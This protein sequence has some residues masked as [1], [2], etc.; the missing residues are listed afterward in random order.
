MSTPKIR[1]LHDNILVKRQESE[2]VTTGGLFI[3]ETRQTKNRFCEVLAVGPGKFRENSNE[4]I[5][6][7]IEP[8]QVVFIRG[9]AGREVELEGQKGLMFVTSDEVEGIIE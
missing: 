8:G 3:P 1:P 4:R 7:G 9:T 2:K 5:P 6:V